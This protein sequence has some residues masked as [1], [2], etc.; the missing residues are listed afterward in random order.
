[1]RGRRG[2]VEA[3]HGEKMVATLLST[4]PAAAAGQTLLAWLSA[5]FRYF[6][7]AGWSQA[8]D[9]GRV[10]RNGAPTTADSCLAAGDRI[11]FT[12]LGAAPATAAV[13]VLHH[14]DDL[15]AVDKP[16]HL[17]VQAATA[18]PANS[19]P[20][21]IAAQ[22]GALA[23]GP[24][25][26]V[27]R[28]DR[29]TSGT[30]VFARNRSAAQACQRQFEAGAVHKEYLAV[31]HGR[32]AADRLLVEAPIGPAP[33]SRIAAWH[34]VVATGSRGARMARTTFVLLQ[35][36]DGASLLRVLPHT[37]RTHQIRVHLE[38]LGH[39]L[40]GDK[41][42]GHADEHWLA[43]VAHLKA[44]GDP[45]W[46]GRADPDRQLL[47]AERLQLRHPRRD[48]TLDLRA[49]W[50]ADLRAAVLARGGSAR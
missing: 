41:L 50:P 13:P 40:L 29:E 28:L 36:L 48:E 45:R 4:V 19:L 34:A 49:P 26:P 1:M 5:R 17:V 7:A 39:A 22:W 30:L 27:H 9:Q 31:V 35:H 20:M 11:G 47:H 3:V 15:L 16:P 18:F 33:H 37:G 43:Y 24:L 6:D 2:T 14:D 46:P 38:H 44:D 25:E 21:A 23:D 8:I 10:Q 32:F 12:P 42:Y